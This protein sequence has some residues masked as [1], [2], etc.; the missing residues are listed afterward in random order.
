MKF[1]QTVQHTRT[2][3]VVSRR[4]DAWLADN[5]HPRYSREAL[6]FAAAQLARS[7]DR[8]RQGTVSASSLGSCPRYQQ[9]VFLG[10]PKL[11]KSPKSTLSCHNGVMMHLRWQMA[12]LTEGWLTKAEVPIRDDHYGLVG[13][14]DG[15]A[16][17][18]SVVELKSIS[19][20]GF[21]SIMTF[22][23]K[24]E[25][26]FQMGT[27]LLSTGREKGVFIY[28]NKDNQEYTEIV[29]HRDELPMDDIVDTARDLWVNLL[30]RT[31]YEPLG[32]CIDKEGWQYQYCPFRDRCLGIR[33]WDE[34][35]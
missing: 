31:L 27:Y 35:A 32:K 28:E 34:V 20:H 30:T 21:S 18:E 6:D 11:A 2:D 9:F 17:D 7:S 24:H 5:D 1:S 14:M 29:V 16:Y 23:P 15:I 33:D 12:G 8:V 22:G 19:S 25:H 26:L 3:L 13:T 4:H 10:M